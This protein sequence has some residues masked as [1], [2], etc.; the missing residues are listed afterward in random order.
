[1]KKLLFI[2]VILLLPT[3]I[4][5]QADSTKQTTKVGVYFELLGQG[6]LYSLN[7]ELVTI[8]R[9]SFKLGAGTYGESGF[10][11]KTTTIPI[12]ANYL[13]PITNKTIFFESGL[14][15][16]FAFSKDEYDPD[17]PL[18]RLY[19]GIS[20]GFK[21]EE[22]KRKGGFLKLNCLILYNSK[23]SEIDPWPGLAFGIYI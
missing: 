10:I 8:K 18:L 16:T 17:S 21:Y 13:I 12:S 5:A 6:F 3:R 14:A 2:F 22:P 20:L 4:L 7:L 1:M 23:A 15:N 9:I 11:Q 19:P